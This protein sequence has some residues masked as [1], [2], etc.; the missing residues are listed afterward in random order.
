M[1]R[2]LVI[3]DSCTDVYTYCKTNRLA[4]DKPVPIV[5]V[6]KVTDNPGMAFNV[7]CNAAALVGKEVDIATNDNYTQVTK[8]RYV[9]KVSNH[10][11]LRVD[12]SV[13]IERISSITDVSFDYDTVIVSDYN[14]GFLAEE[15]IEYICEM[16]PRVFLDTK[17]L[18]GPWAKGAKFIKINN[19]EYERSHE[20][21]DKYLKDKV[22][23]TLGSKGCLYQGDIYPTKSIEAFDLSG[24][25]DTFMAC[26]AV[27]YT[28][29][30]NI[31]KAIK[32]ANKGATWVV[33]RRGT[34]TILPG[35]I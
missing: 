34:T 14:K 3:G 21:I 32:Y 20:F 7:F 17:K 1:D 8:N 22:I 16:H 28:K 27:S 18:L 23:Q 35:K 5:E 30:Q 4:P 11:F 29:D 13:K 12:S 2:I 25:G 15:D 6:V 9:D 19:H 26:L 10:M 24:A 31:K 33:R